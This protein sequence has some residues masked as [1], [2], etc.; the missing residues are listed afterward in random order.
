M[1]ETRLTMPELALI[2]GTRAALGA[3]AALLIGDRL[4][5]ETR[6]AVGWTLFLIGAV[7]TVPLLA[8]VLGRRHEK[9]EDTA[10][11]CVESYE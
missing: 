2:A 3:G 7:T 4:P 1:K 6:K 11:R 10:T 9:Q 5:K 8:E